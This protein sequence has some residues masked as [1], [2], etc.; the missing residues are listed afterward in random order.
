MDKQVMITTCLWLAWLTADCTHKIHPKP[1]PNEKQVVI[2]GRQ[3]VERWSELFSAFIQAPDK[4][5]CVC[6]AK[7]QSGI[8]EKLDNNGNVQKPISE[9]LD[10][11]L[12]LALDF[13]PCPGIVVTI[14]LLTLGI[15]N[16]IL[17]KLFSE[18]P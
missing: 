4:L 3:I 17:R 5:K 8:V 13:E 15:C 10:R 14:Y 16:M 9:R 6:A 12:R 18:L 1:C 7:K 11:I 2:A